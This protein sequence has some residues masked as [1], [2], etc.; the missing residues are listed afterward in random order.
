MLSLT[1][2]LQ[3]QEGNKALINVCSYD[4]LRPMAPISAVNILS[5]AY[6]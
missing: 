4:L 3:K 2:A 1:L 5:F 6:T